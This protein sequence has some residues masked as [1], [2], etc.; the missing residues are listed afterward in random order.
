MSSP[1]LYT[2]RQC[3]Y[4]I[5][6]RLGLL[7]AEINFEQRDIDLRQKPTDML[8]ISNKGTV[9]LLVFENG[10]YIDESLEVMIWA[11]NNND[12]HDLLLSQKPHYFPEMLSLIARNDYKYIT[13]LEHYK[14]DTRYHNPEAPV[15]RKLCESFLFDLE[16]RLSQHKYLMADQLS[17]ADYA[18]LPF[19][20]QFSHVER[21]WFREA[22]YPNLKQWLS[23]LYQD[24]IFSKAM[25]KY[26]LW[27]SCTNTQATQ[28]NDLTMI[29]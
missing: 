4:A 25:T 24:P 26:P 19:I 22:N 18:I 27:E 23:D 9:P 8:A 15:Y 1:I 13:A 2:L 12:P 17:L 5:R 14:A 20:R 3:P 10:D 6:A 21:Q 11:L 16:S 28:H 7:L 29:S